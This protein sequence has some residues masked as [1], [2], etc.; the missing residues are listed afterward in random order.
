VTQ[1][2][3]STRLDWARITELFHQ[4]CERPPGE[5]QAFLE[6]A[7]AGDASVRSEVDAL[8]AA[9]DRAGTFMETAPAGATALIALAERSGAAL[10]GRSIAQYQVER[11]LGAGGMGIVYLATDNRLGRTVALK[12]IPPRFAA[13]E[14]RRERLK[15]EARAAATL[16]HP[17]IATVYALE[18][19]DDQWLI[20]SEYVAG[21]TLRDEIARGP[22]P[23]AVVVDTAL[24]LARGLAAAHERGIL[25]RDLKPENVIRRQDGSIKILDFGLARM[26]ESEPAAPSTLTEEGRLVGTP[27][28]MSPEQLRGQP[29]DARSD[30]FAL[31]VLVHELISARHPFDSGDRAT[32]TAAILERDPPVLT[33]PPSAAS[34]TRV[35]YEGLDAIVRG[36][37]E[38]SV[39]RRYQSAAELVA[40][41]EALQRGSRVP[42]VAGAPAAHWWW[43]FHQAGIIA[44]YTGIL[45]LLFKIVDVG[46]ET[47]R[48]SI[49]VLALASALASITLRL[50]LW[51][52]LTNLPAEWEAQRK[53]AAIWI[54]IADLTLVCDEMAGAIVAIADHR[55]LALALLSA[56]VVQFLVATVIEPATAR[57]AFD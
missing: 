51:F 24:A 48:L 44:A 16:N 12:A 36:C 45:V 35:Q 40:A 1:Q 32:V 26:L 57:A 42:A 5:R 21:E 55:F 50:H 17:N 13:D 46:P 4:A 56:A 3:G 2:S 20:A 10:V 25:H 18:Q 15:R 47:Y 54:R 11:V 19:I 14:R 53:R 30:L 49:V 33:P 29:I 52:T 22:Q 34:S 43:R 28:Y 9:H 41:L 23:I 38:K 31:G 39:T 6:A 37:L 8:L 7:C 27:S